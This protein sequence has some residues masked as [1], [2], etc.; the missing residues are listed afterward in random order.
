L[1]QAG[2]DLAE[3]DD[4]EEATV[5]GVRARISDPVPEQ[6]QH[7]RRDDSLFRAPVQHVYDD[8]RDEG[9]GKQE[10]RAQPV[11]GGL[12]SVEELS[13]LCGDGGESEP[14]AR[15]VSISRPA[16]SL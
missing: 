9:E 2:Q 5:G 13:G 14:L 16:M 7:G 15:E 1:S 6:Q 12:V 3:H 8:G 10:G 4:A 11:D